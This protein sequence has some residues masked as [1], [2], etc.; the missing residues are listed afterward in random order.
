[1]TKP[2]TNNLTVQRVLPYILIVTAVIGF[3][4]SFKLTIEHINLYKDP[5]HLFDCNLNPI[6][7]CGPVMKSKEAVIFGFPNPIM[8]LAMFAAQATIG[9]VMLAGAK[10]KSWFWKLYGLGILGGLAFTL[11]LMYSSI[12]NLGAICIY[13]MTV[14]ITMFISSWYVFQ[15]M[16]AEKHVTLKSSKLTKFLRVHHGE[17]LTVWFL[18]VTALILH[19]FWYYFGSLL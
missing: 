12:F 2:K 9:A 15:F 16:L 1:M 10:M 5:G 11:W 3:L 13:C 14:W 4:A 8:G 6:L 19:E 17:I 7:S 18:V